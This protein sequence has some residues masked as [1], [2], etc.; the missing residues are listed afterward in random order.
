MTDGPRCEPCRCFQANRPHLRH[1]AFRILGS[2]DDADDA[3]QQK[4]IKASQADL[5]G[6]QNI[7][8]WLTTVIA[9][10]CFDPL[11]AQQ[12]R[13]ERCLPDEVEAA[14]RSVEDEVV[15]AESVGRALLIVLDRLTPPERVA[16][17]LHDTFAVPFEEL[18]GFST[19]PR[20]RRRNSPAGRAERSTTAGRPHPRGRLSSDNWRVRS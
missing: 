3:V 6:V 15:L 20:P 5:R 2:L 7:A 10:E 8:G 1:V 14:G 19:D 13:G 18:G 11:R 16:V 12:R 4:W 17:V 9:R